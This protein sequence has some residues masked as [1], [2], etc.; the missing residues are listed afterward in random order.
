VSALPER[1][2]YERISEWLADTYRTW[3]D[4]RSE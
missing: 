3:W 2:D 1:P 4:E